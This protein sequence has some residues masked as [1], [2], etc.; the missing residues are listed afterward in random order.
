MFIDTSAI[1]AILNR[2]T[3][4]EGLV[5]ALEV[6]K[7]PPHVSPVTRMDAI[8]ALATSR[9]PLDRAITAAQFAQAEHAVD[10]LLSELK[11]KS[12]MISDSIG[13][14]AFDALCRYGRDA[15]HDAA[16]TYGD[17]IAYACAKAYR[18]PL[19]YSG[20]HFRKT[21]LA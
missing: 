10:A 3:G 18:L 2:E 8:A 7:T 16:L 5:K 1:L 17:C 6:A 14:A 15:G 21:D 13:H 4:W 19:L 11:T 12:V 20:E 9:V